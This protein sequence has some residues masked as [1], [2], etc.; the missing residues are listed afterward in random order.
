MAAVKK[1]PELVPLK[2]LI[3]EKNHRVVAAEANK[4]FVDILFSFLTLPMGTIMRLITSA[5]E[6]TTAAVPVGCMKNLYEGVQNL[7]S[8]YWQT[9]HCKNMVLNPR[10]PLA[11]YCKSLKINIDDSGPELTYGCNSVYEFVNN[12]ES[13]MFYSEHLAAMERG[14][15]KYYSIY[16]NVKCVC[17]KGITT[18]EMTAK[19]KAGDSSSEGVSFLKRGIEFLISDNLQ[20]RPA[21]P[22]VLA[23]LIPDIGSADGTRIREMRVEASKVEVI[24]LLACALVSETPLSDVFLG[25][26][27]GYGIVGTQGKRPRLENNFSSSQAALP[28]KSTVEQNGHT[29]KLKVTYAKSTKEI[30]FGEATN[31]FFDFLCTFLTIPIGSMMRVLEGKSGLTCMDNLYRSVLDLDHKWFQESAKNNLLNPCI[32]KYH[33]CKKQPLKSIG[34]E[35]YADSYYLINPRE[36]D[37]FAVEPSMFLVPD[38]LGVKSLSGASSFLLLKD[39]GIPFSQTEVQ[40]V[41][42]G[43]KEA[44]SLLKA[45]LTSPSSALS[46]G[47]GP[48]L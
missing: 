13:I 40:W 9:E 11:K 5:N 12:T 2:L 21:S 26:R 28:V 32:A 36:S 3:D 48:Y 34:T 29:L 8:E 43:T 20:V 22:A 14:R 35:S 33:N 39:M 6:K 41:T 15:C 10:N 17:G 46:N 44:L 16:R 31:E 24:Y 30:L 19:A 38:D 4:D 1:E 47:L 7:S 42:L 27:P 25:K 23:Q 45:A 37:N 18:K